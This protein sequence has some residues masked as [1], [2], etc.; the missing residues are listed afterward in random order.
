MCYFVSLLLV[1]S[2]SAINCLERLVSEMTRYV[3]SETSN[4]TNTTQ[5]IFC[6]LE[7]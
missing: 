7:L 3:A 5:H 1:V 4:D 6:V 2:T